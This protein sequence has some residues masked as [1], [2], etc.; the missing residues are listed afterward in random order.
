MRAL[1]LGADG[2]LRHP[3]EPEALLAEIGDLLQKGGC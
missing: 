2:F 3:V 1:A